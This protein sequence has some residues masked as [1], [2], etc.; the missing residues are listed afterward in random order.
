MFADQPFNARLIAGLG[1]GLAL[2]GP[3]S[4]ADVAPAVRAV[5][6]SPGYRERAESVADEINALPVVDDAV[7]VLADLAAVPVSPRG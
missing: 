5:L 3:E 1:A 7:G 4:I 6:G 2:D